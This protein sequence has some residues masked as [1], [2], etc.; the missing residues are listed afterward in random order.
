MYVLLLPTTTHFLSLSM[1]RRQLNVEMAVALRV[2]KMLNEDGGLEKQL[3]GH[4]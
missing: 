2:V 3:W 4:Q 1:N